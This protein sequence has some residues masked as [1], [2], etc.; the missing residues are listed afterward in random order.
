MLAVSRT[1]SAW[2]LLFIVG[3]LGLHFLPESHTY[4]IFYSGDGEPWSKGGP[5]ESVADSSLL[6]G[7]P[8]RPFGGTEAYQMNLNEEGGFV[9]ASSDPLTNLLPARDGLKRYK[10]RSGDTLPSI[11]AQFGI[12]ANTV[13]WANQGISLLRV[14][15]ELIILPVSGILY[16]VNEND[17]LEI[18]ADRYQIEGEAIKKQNPDYQKVIAGGKGNLILPDAKPLSKNA[19][20]QSAQKLPDLRNYFTLPVAGYNW[21]ELHAEN[22]VDIANACGT[23][24]YAAAEGLVVVDSEWGDGSGEWNNGYGHFVLLEHSNGTKTRYAHLSKIGVAIGDQ[25]GRGAEIGTMGNSGNTD[26][27][28]GC[29]LHF[30]VYGAKN[31]FATR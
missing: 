22:A 2:S 8:L 1:T 26:G 17:S 16:P 10:V 25:V 11:A 15:Q 21:A 6:S 13:K 5:V 30:E 18:I 29:H 27:P 31:P 23:P 19:Y 7:L 3:M 4:A 24:V 12:T 20:T 9:Q 14:G 28:T